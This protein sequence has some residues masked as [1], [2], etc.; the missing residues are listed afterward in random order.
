MLNW[1]EVQVDP[2]HVGHNFFARKENYNL[3]ALLP[4]I[5]DRLLFKIRV[6]LACKEAEELA[7]TNHWNLPE[8]VEE[9]D[10]WFGKQD[11][12]YYRE[13]IVRL[14]DAGIFKT[15]LVEAQNDEVYSM[16]DLRKDVAN[17]KKAMK[18]TI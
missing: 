15:E 17:L 13:K 1:D 6:I 2:E 18:T 16:K 4:I 10:F 9:Y 14:G 3:T 8:N 7:K 5:G 11:D 12:K